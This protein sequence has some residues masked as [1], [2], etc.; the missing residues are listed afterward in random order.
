MTILL[1]SIII[2]NT[3]TP[4]LPRALFA[5]RWWRRSFFLCAVTMLFLFLQQLARRVVPPA[6]G[7]HEIKGRS[8]ESQTRRLFVHAPRVDDDDAM[9]VPA[10][11]LRAHMRA[12][13]PTVKPRRPPRDTRAAPASGVMMILADAV[14]LCSQCFVHLCVRRPCRRFRQSVLA[15]CRRISR[16]A[17]RALKLVLLG[18]QP[19][20]VLLDPSVSGVQGGPERFVFRFKQLVPCFQ[21]PKDHHP[22]PGLWHGLVGA[23]SRQVYLVTLQMAGAPG[24]GCEHLKS[25]RDIYVSSVGSTFR[26]ALLLCPLSYLLFIRNWF[27]LTRSCFGRVFAVVFALNFA[28]VFAIYA[29]VLQ[30]TCNSDETDNHDHACQSK[31]HHA[32]ICVHNIS[33]A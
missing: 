3:P 1:S 14:Y 24:P 10:S 30:H 2:F 15:S 23:A 31:Q 19:R 8:I 28:V 7:K 27:F 33:K 21:F 26:C 22:A 18:G 6:R 29:H 25:A 12:H 9:L 11:T 17:L 4:P 32:D 20:L 5:P 13:Q 16:C